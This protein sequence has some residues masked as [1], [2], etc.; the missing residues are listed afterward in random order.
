MLSSSTNEKSM[1]TLENNL[2]V[3]PIYNKKKQ[4]F[5]LKLVVL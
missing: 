3:L 2:S 1:Y 4:Y 5:L